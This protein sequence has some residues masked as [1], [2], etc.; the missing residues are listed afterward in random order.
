MAEAAGG[1]QAAQPNDAPPEQ[2]DEA[3]AKTQGAPDPASVVADEDFVSPSGHR[4]T[5]VHTDERDA[6]ETPV[7]PKKR[8]RRARKGPSS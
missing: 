1:G 3:E 4:Y 2:Q 7:R 8:R 5:I 6:Y